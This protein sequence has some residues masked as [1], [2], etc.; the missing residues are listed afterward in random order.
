MKKRLLV[1]LATAGIIGGGV[2]GFAATL[3]VNSDNLG[4]GGDAVQSCDTGVDASYTAAYT[5]TGYRV[6]TVELSGIAALCEGE[7][8]QITLSNA[9]DA[10][11]VELTGVIGATPTQSVVVGGTILAAAVE[12][13][14]VVITGDNV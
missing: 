5:A 14:D 4:S 7:S 12:G 11:M 10:S 6:A 1:G 9:A 3:N 2:Y 13:I 8:F